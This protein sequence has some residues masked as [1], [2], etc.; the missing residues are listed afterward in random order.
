MTKILLIEDEP[1]HTMLAK[2]RL[3][4]EGFEVESA[5]TGVEGVAEAGKTAPDV[6][7]LDLVLPDMAPEELIASLRSAA[8]TERTPIILF[9]ALDAYELQRKRLDREI[10]GLV[11]KPYEPGELIREI[12]RVVKMQ[13]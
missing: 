11:Q 12:K 2:I 4:A 10:S 5:S 13:D 8:Y 1:Q 6:I 3:K 9:T 7:L